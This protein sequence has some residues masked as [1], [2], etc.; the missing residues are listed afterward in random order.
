MRL[1]NCWKE[2]NCNCN[3]DFHHAGVFNVEG[4]NRC[5]PK[6]KPLPGKYQGRELDIL[7]SKSLR[8]IEKS[9]EPNNGMNRVTTIPEVS[10]Y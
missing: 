4:I 7:G 9:E 10:F 6:T 3:Y 5:G 2:T 1:K 8:T